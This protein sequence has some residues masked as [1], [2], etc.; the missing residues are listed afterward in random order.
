[1]ISTC[2]IGPLSPLCIFQRIIVSIIVLAVKLHGHIEVMILAFFPFAA[3]TVFIGFS[4]NCLVVLF[5]SDCSHCFVLFIGFYYYLWGFSSGFLFSSWGTTIKM[6]NIF[7]SIQLFSI[8]FSVHYFT[9]L[10]YFYK[11]SIFLK[12]L[13]NLY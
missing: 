5:L 7:Q 10:N 11:I 13:I 1:M 12:F 3:F 6:N 9:N 4:W 8:F 2:A